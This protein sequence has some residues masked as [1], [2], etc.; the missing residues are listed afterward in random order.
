MHYLTSHPVNNTR[1]CCYQKIIVIQKSRAPF[2]FGYTAFGKHNPQS[3]VLTRS[4]SMTV[5]SIIVLVFFSHTLLGLK[6][7]RN[8]DFVLENYRLGIRRDFVKLYLV[9]WIKNHSWRAYKNIDLLFS[10]IRL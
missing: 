9:Q 7:V 5:D 1:K 10:L 8:E 4:R 6:K 2:L 3:C